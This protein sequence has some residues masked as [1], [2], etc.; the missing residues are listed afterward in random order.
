MDTIERKIIEHLYLKEKMKAKH[1][2][3][4]LN[5]TRREVNQYLYYK[6]NDV[7]VR[8]LL[9]QWSLK[10]PIESEEVKL[11][12]GLIPKPQEPSPI[13][14]ENCMN[15]RRGLCNGRGHICDDF[16]PAPHLSKE[17]L[18]LWPKYGD[19]TRIRKKE[20]EKEDKKR[21]NGIE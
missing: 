11:I 10:Q 14:C 17:E 8:D 18:K 19:A 3:K 4:A 9:F 16:E 7:C 15:F 6:L 2:A 5:L 1:L 20:Q 21:K 13:R 12:I